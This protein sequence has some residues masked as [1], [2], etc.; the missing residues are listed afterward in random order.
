MENIEDIKAALV[1]VN[2][3]KDA[4]SIEL[5]ANKAELATTKAAL[6]T[7]KSKN[8]ALESA[9][10]TATEQLTEAQNAP[11]KVPSVSAKA[12]TFDADWSEKTFK[13]GKK[14]WGFL[15]PQ[16]SYKGGDVTYKDILADTTLQAEL[17]EAKHGCLSEK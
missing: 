9:L 1:K 8:T 15:V 10:A 2:A 5:V 4:I 7:E 6:D 16:F 3:E 12:D 17:V 13:N 14:T 11:V